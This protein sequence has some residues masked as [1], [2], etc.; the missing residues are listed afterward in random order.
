[1]SGFT[2]A[3]FAWGALDSAQSSSTIAPNPADKPH[4]SFHY[5]H[6]QLQPAKY[7]FVIFEDGRGEFHS[8][9]SATPPH[10]TLSYQTMAH[11]LDRP[12]QLSKTAVEEIFSTARA[13]RFFAVSCEDVKDKVAF[14][15]TKQLSYAGPDGNGS[16]TYNWSKIAPIQKVTTTFESIAFTLEVG[17]RLEVEHK[18]DRLALDAEL[19]TLLS[20]AKD[21]RALEIQTIQPILE[22]ISNDEA[23]LERARSRARKLL[24]D[25]STTASLR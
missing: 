5:E 17:R 7:T 19:A 3:A 21:G 6:P 24:G 11:P 1:M 8:E 18:H 2:G 13:Q 15:G 9:P 25:D 22:E 12:V 10:D 4:V 20:A 23:V 14:Q 16:C